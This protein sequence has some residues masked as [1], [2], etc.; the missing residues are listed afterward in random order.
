MKLQGQS[1][2]EV[3]LQTTCG[4]LTLAVQTAD[5]T[6]QELSE[7]LHHFEP[8]FRDIQ[9]DKQALEDKVATLEGTLSGLRR[10][11]VTRDER[12]TSLECDL[13]LKDADSAILAS[14]LSDTQSQLEQARASE[15]QVL[16]QARAS[17]AQVLE[18]GKRLDDLQHDLA[19]SEQ[20]NAALSER[21]TEVQQLNQEQ[22]NSFVMV[23]QV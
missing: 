2:T 15:A 5:H 7:K 4:D 23:T 6:K 9:S 12:V 19:H 11:R 18:Q 17:E 1:D 20:S 14:T 3:M 10:E 8:V 13:Q 22:V 21:L 16:E